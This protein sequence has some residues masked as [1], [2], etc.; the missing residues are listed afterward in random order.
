MRDLPNTLLTI[1]FYY[2]ALK[3]AHNLGQPCTIFDGKALDVK[4]IVMPPHRFILYD[5]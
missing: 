5:P 3:L 4:V 1:P 2:L